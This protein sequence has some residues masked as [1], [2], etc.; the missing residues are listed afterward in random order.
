MWHLYSGERELNA[1]LAGRMCCFDER[2]RVQKKTF[3]KWVNKHLMKVRKHI[4]DL[5]EDLRDGHNLISLLEV[6]S[7]VKLQ[8]EPPGPKS[9]R[10]AKAPA[11]RRTSS[12]EREEEEDGDA[13]GWLPSGSDGMQTDTG[14]P[15]ERPDL[16]TL[17]PG[18]RATV[19]P[20]T[21]M[22]AASAVPWLGPSARSGSGLSPHVR[23]APSASLARGLVAVRTPSPQ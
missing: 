13:V 10:L 16:A 7:G 8:K 3:T 2:D 4:N 5:Y 1:H 21:P 19:Q 18:L 20:A 9:L 12:E 22:P 15:S 23:A 6:L 14:V 11:W 17:C